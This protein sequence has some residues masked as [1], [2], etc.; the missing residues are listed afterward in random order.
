MFSIVTVASSTRMPTAS[1]SPPS[2]MMLRVSPS[3]HS[4]AIEPSTE[5]GID[6]A[7]MSVERKL[8]RNNRIIRL[9]K[10]AAM[11][12]SR[13]TPPIAALMKN[14]WSPI[15]SMVSV[16]G[17]V[18][19]SCTSFFLMPSM[20]ASVETAPFLSTIIRTE[21]LPSTWTMLVCGGLPSRTCA[22]SSI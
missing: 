7:M 19:L 13:M 8:P 10:A 22:T 14:D 18:A 1:A 2:V 6:V 15:C 21:R 12:P 16:C 9:V 4:V 5:S 20:I 3:A 17:N 11:T